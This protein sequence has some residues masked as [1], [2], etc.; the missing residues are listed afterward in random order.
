MLTILF[1]I[2]KEQPINQIKPYFRT[3][4]YLPKIIREIE[5]FKIFNEIYE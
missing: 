3:I 1:A 2:T 5:K 4:K